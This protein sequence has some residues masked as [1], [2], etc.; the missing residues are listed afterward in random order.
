MPFRLHRSVRLLILAALLIAAAPVP[1]LDMPDPAT[2]PGATNP[3]ITQA[4]I[5]RTICHPGWSTRSIRPPAS[6]TGALKRRQLANPRYTDK[7]PANYEE[8]HLIPLEIG[9]AP[10]DPKNLWPEA[11]AG[12]CGARVK[13]RLEDKLHALVCTSML[14]LAAAQ[15][16]ISADWEAA[17]RQYV[18]PLTCGE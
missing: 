11:Y 6:Y 4:T 13:D 5:D 2:T 7:S 12:P 10:R 18:G 15:R 8:D 17:Y 16:A 1:A 9:G 3:D 14:T